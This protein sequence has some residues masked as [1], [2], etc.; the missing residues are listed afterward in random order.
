MAIALVTSTKA[1]GQNGGTSAGIDTTG[2]N[3]IV[4]GVVSYSAVGDATV[5]DSKGNTPYVGLTK[6][7]ATALQYVKIFYFLS[8][9]VGSGHT[10]TVTSSAGF[11]AM[12]VASFSGVSAFDAG[13]DTGA[14]TAS[15]VTTLQVGSLTPSVDN[16]LMVTVVGLN[17]SSSTP[18]IDS[19]FNA[20]TEFQNYVGSTNFGAALSYQVQ[21]TA[22]ARNPTWTFSLTTGAAAAMAVFKPP[23]A[24]G[25]LF[26]RSSLDGLSTSGP[27]QFPRMGT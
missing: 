12:V 10:F 15:A 24:G 23:A 9:T 26:G 4:L 11:S 25:S 3:L 17:A 14:S 5:S 6:Y 16:C 20:A 27:K 1:A 18:T 13:K 22:T 7:T 19:S 8:P 2:A 21:T